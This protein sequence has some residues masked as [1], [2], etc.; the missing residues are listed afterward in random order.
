MNYIE[1]ESVV[2]EE[3][4]FKRFLIWSSGQSSCLVEQN[5]LC[6]FERGHYWECS[7]EVIWNLD[8]W[9]RRLL[10]KDISY[11]VLWQPLS[12][13]VQR[14]RTICAILVE[15]IMRILFVLIL[16]FPSTIFQL[17]RDVSSWVEPVLS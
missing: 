13:F 16:Y 10:F 8:Q 11:L 15:G 7:C 4:L 3:M 17:N 2:Q 12:G 5:H 9:F 1:F 6:N 14:T